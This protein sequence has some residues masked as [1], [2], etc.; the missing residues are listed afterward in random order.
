MS[1]SVSSQGC[2]NGSAICKSL[3]VIQHISRSKDKNHMMI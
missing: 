3:N 1:K 2:R